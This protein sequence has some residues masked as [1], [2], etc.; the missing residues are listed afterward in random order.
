MTTSKEPIQPSASVD[1]TQ[2]K[3]RFGEKLS[4]LLATMA[5]Y[6]LLGLTSGYLMIFYTNVIGLNPIAIG[7]LFL[8]SKIMDGI[9]DPINGYLIDRLPRTKFGKYRSV[10]IGGTI[11]CSSQLPAF[12]VRPGLGY[13]GQVDDCLYQLPDTW[14][15]LRLHGY[16]EEQF[17]PAMTANSKERSSLGMLIALGTILS[18][19]VVAIIAP[20]IL[21]AGDLSSESIFHACP[22]RHRCR[23]CCWHRWSIG[24]K[25]T[26][27][28]G[29]YGIQALIE[30]LPE[31]FDPKASFRNLDI[32]FDVLSCIIHPCCSECL[33]LYLCNEKPGP[34][35]CGCTDTAGWPPSGYFPG[36]GNFA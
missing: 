4:Y 20:L 21:S 23:V 29:R 27:R 17:S 36:R 15:Q 8:L 28:S 5:P 7:T 34:G 31:C 19:M 32:W 14:Y 18:G 11:I 16:P 35:Q 3:L 30:G 13:I 22:D 24:R 25:G 9:S 12:M 2:E 10:M 26:R 1:I 6:P 33:F